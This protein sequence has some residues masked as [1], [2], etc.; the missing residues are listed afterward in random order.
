MASQTRC[1]PLRVPTLQ[2]ILFGYMDGNGKVPSFPIGWAHFATLGTILPGE[3]WTAEPGY[4]SDHYINF[5]MITTNESRT[6]TLFSSASVP[7]T[8][9]M[10]VLASVLAGCQSASL[11]TQNDAE[12]VRADVVAVIDGED[13]TLQ[14][15]TDNF[16]RNGRISPSDSVSLTAYEDFLTRYVDFRLKVKEAQR[17]GLDEDPALQAEVLDYRLQLAR[18]YIMER[19]VFEPLVMEMYDRRKEMVEASHILLTLD[20]NASPE[21]TLAAWTTLAG[22]RDSV[23]AGASF[24]RLAAQ[25]S[26]DPS[27]KGQPG[28]PGYQGQLGYFGGG[29]MVEAFEDM[30]YKTPVGSV[31]EIFRTRFGYHI[32]QVTDR[33]P[34]PQDRELAH[35]M[36]RAQGS[37]PADMA[38][39]QSKI[40]SVQARLAAGLSFAEVAESYSEDQNSAGRGGNIGRLAYDAGLPFPFRDAAFSIENEGDWTGPIQTQFGYHFI[41]Y[42]KEWPLGSFDEEYESMKNRISQMPRT[43]AAQDAFAYRVV[44]EVGAWVDSSLVRSWVAAM[45]PD[46]LVRWITLTDFAAQDEDPVFV[47]FADYSLTLSGYRDYF[48]RIVTPS[49]RRIE[50][51]IYG[52]VDEWL[53][54][55]AVDY[56]IDQLEQR[57]AEFAATMSDFRDGLLL[58]RFMEQEI[59]EKASSDTTAQERFFN[60]RKESYRYPDRTRVISY[61]TPTQ[62]G[63]EAFVSNVRRVGRT[64]ALMDIEGDSTL[65]LRADTTFIGEATGSMFDAVLDMNEG[66]ITDAQAF[67][68]GWIA[69]YNDGIDPAR[70]MTFEEARSAVIN[71]VQAA[72]EAQMMEELRRRFNVSVYPEVLQQLDQ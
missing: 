35:I 16:E 71:E 7:L 10:I 59:W 42:V 49:A 2:N 33:Q 69:L 37:S 31:S 68:Q 56:E 1:A 38:A 54:E 3:A 34:M 36:V 70:S 44:E 62:E 27:A 53:A 11:S 4:T 39:S 47:Q 65:V 30:A 13:L 50:D 5:R 61:S 20:A 66:E 40:D 9:F 8:A 15:F 60:E 21:D 63:V 23:V 45:E 24:G 6:Q 43:Q 51:R 19:R 58:F 28:T 17:I 25:F 67:N 14:D 57:D 18:P 32:L 64:Q 26:Q 29:R 41:Q 22:I 48:R 12:S 72:K 52:V 46:S 55:R